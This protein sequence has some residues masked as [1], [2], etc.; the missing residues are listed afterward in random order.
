MWCVVINMFVKL[1]LKLWT[2]E[3]LFVEAVILYPKHLV[4]IIVMKL[5]KTSLS[6]TKIQKNTL[7]HDKLTLSGQL[8]VFISH[9]PQLH[10][11]IQ[12][13]NGW[14]SSTF[15]Y[16]EEV[17]GQCHKARTHKRE[18][19]KAE[20]FDNWINDTLHLV[21]KLSLIQ[22]Q[23]RKKMKLRNLFSISPHLFA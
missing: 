12:Q 21:I 15:N 23:V 11:V 10:I 18:Q 13:Q 3:S 22:S 6:K 16:P 14:S 7:V 4:Y 8:K 9:T 1:K 19:I 2:P 20:T 17:N 5:R